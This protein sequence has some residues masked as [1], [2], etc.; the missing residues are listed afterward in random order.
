MVVAQGEGLDRAVGLGQRAV[1]QEDQRRQMPHHLIF[2]TVF[3]FHHAVGLNADGLVRVIQRQHVQHV[4][5]GIG[6]AH[7]IFRQRQL[8]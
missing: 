1:A 2:G 6:G 4:A 5:E 7:G 3:N 8:P